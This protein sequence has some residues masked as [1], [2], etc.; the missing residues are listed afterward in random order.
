MAGMLRSALKSDDG[1]G[2]LAFEMKTVAHLMKRG[3][4]VEFHDI[5][6]GGGFDYLATNETVEIEIECKFISG[7]LGRKIHLKEFHQLSTVLLPEMSNALD[8]SDG[9]CLVRILIPRRLE[10]NI[11]QHNEIC[12]LMTHALANHES[13]KK[14]SEYGVSILDIPVQGN[15]SDL[16]SQGDVSLD[17]FK[18]FLFNE[19]GIENRNVII[20]FR[21]KKGVIFVVVES[22]KKDP[23]L[24]AIHR[25][26]KAS[27][28]N[29]LSGDRPGILCCY[30]AEVT[31]EVLLG[32][33]NHQDE[34]TGLQFMVSNLIA[35]RPEIHS[36]V[37]TTP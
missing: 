34:G 4:N 15:L 11:Q 14:Y 35:R 30:L 25:Q 9:G 19:H 37:F 6:E 31:K 36:V 21:P 26:L 18:K 20:N 33:W 22:T 10:A 17:D 5:E 16:I 29:Q 2:P 1:F 27:A 23:V 13:N 28:R 3:F 32:L 12:R 7:D 8:Q 24:N